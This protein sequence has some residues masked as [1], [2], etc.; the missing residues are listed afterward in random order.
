[1]GG[2]WGRGGLDGAGTLQHSPGARIP[3]AGSPLCGIL[4]HPGDPSLSP[5]RPRSCPRHAR[6][7]A[8]PQRG[9]DEGVD[10]VPRRCSGSHGGARGR[11]GGSDDHSNLVLL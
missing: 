4:Y 6:T 11:H 8:H 2:C 1:D 10:T 3:G 5:G 7:T 9:E